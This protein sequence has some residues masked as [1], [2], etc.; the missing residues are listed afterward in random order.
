MIPQNTPIMN[1]TAKVTGK[2]ILIES[3]NLKLN[4]SKLNSIKTD[5][6]DIKNVFLFPKTGKI[7]PH[8]SEPIV[9][10]IESKE[11]VRPM[12]SLTFVYSTE[13]EL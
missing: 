7:A 6:P 1:I 13:L 5:V 9:S 4:D 12:P 3:I 8:E 11:E 10:P 2:T